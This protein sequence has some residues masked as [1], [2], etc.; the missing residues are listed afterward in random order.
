MTVSKNVGQGVAATTDNRKSSRFN[1]DFIKTLLLL[2]ASAILIAL[3]R[4]ISPALG[5]WSQV[6]T[7]LTLGSFLLVV[8]FGQG[9]VIMTGGLDLSIPSTLMLGGVLCAGMIG[10]QDNGVWYNF[11]LI[12]AICAG[13]GALNGIGVSLLRIPPFIMTMGMN[14]IL[15]SAALGYSGGSTLGASPTFLTTLMK[16]DLAGVPN[17]IL[18]V[19]LFS[20]VGWIV[21]Q[22]TVFGRNL[23]AL[24]A[25]QTAAR[26]AGISIHGSII[27]VYAISAVCSAFAGAML[28]GY[29]NGATLSM[30]E[31]YLLPSIAAVIVGG[32]S[33]LGGSGSFVGTVAG[34]L[35]LST[36]ESVIAATGLGHGWRMIISGSIVLGAIL[37]QSPQFSFSPL[38]PLRAWPKGRAARQ[39]GGAE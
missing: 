10:S 23:Y 24:G 36:V 38:K 5:S 7:I 8:A 4:F 2:A 12:L 30:G 31:A 25:S 9:L 32:S 1:A 18:F 16:D 27:A 11:P 29:A 34:V 33:I 28:T 19:V 26:I 20:L 6:L 35:F 17:I 22:R 15:A 39:L 21:Q 3:S 37:M 14:I 13:I